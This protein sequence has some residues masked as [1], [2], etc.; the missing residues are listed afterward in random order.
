M[1]KY[2]KNLRILV[3]LYSRPLS[4]CNLCRLQNAEQIQVLKILYNIS[5]ALVFFTAY[6]DS[7]LAF[8]G[9]NAGSWLQSE[10]STAT[11]FEVV[12]FLSLSLSLF[13]F[14]YSQVFEILSIQIRKHA[15]PRAF[16]PGRC[17]S[18]CVSGFLRLPRGEGVLKGTSRRQRKRSGRLELLH[19]MPH[20][21]IE[22]RGR[23]RASR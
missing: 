16:C 5:C 3:W 14:E 15:T 19:S 23:V 11:L 21:H 1:C 4:S 12:P 10:Q 17:A 18:A 20:R 6:L 2:C 9:T 8:Y 22:L 13:L 7:F